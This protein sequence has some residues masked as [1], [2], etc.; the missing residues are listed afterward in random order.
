[1]ED[2][3]RVILEDGAV[4]DDHLA[5]EIVVVAEAVR[6]ETDVRRVDR[7]EGVRPVVR[8]DREVGRVAA[9]VAIGDDGDRAAEDEVLARGG[10][11][12]P[13]VVVAEP[14]RAEVQVPVAR[15]EEV[16]A[17]VALAAD[18]TA[19]EGDGAREAGV[20]ALELE[21][22]VA[23]LDD[24]RGSADLTA[25]GHETGA[26]LTV[27]SA[28]FD[29]EGDRRGP[30]QRRGAG[31][32]EI[33]VVGVVA[34]GGIAEDQRSPLGRRGAVDRQRGDGVGPGDVEGT[35][36][37]RLA[38]DAGV[39]HV[40]QHADPVGG[41]VRIDVGRAE[42]QFGHLAAIV[43]IEPVAAERDRGRPRRP[44]AVEEETP[45]VEL[46]RPGDGVGRVGEH[47]RAVA[48]GGEARGGDLPSHAR[49]QAVAAEVDHAF[50]RG[51]AVAEVKGGGVEI[52][53]SRGVGVD[54]DEAAAADIDLSAGEGRLVVAGISLHPEGVDIDRARQRRVGDAA[55]EVRHRRRSQA[56]EE[57]R[58]GGGIAAREGTREGGVLDAVDV[59]IGEE[60][61]ARRIEHPDGQESLGIAQRGATLDE[62]FLS[63]QVDTAELV[64]VLADGEGG[65]AFA[66]QPGG[67]KDDLSGGGVALQIDRSAL[68][69]RDDPDFFAGD[70]SRGV[71]EVDGGAAQEHR[72]RVAPLVLRDRGREV[73]G[74][75]A[76]GEGRVGDILRVIET[77]G[78]PRVE[79]HRVDLRARVVGEA[80]TG[81]RVQ[82]AEDMEGGRREVT[83]ELQEVLGTASLAVAEDDRLAR[84]GLVAVKAH[85]SRPAAEGKAEVE[86]RDAHL[87]GGGAGQYPGRS[88][89][90]HAGVV[91]E[92]AVDIADA[93]AEGRGGVEGIG[94]RGHA[95]ST[96]AEEGL[97]DRRREETVVHRQHQGAV[98]TG[99]EP[100][101]RRGGV[102][103]DLDDGLRGRK[104]TVELDRRTAG[105]EDVGR[106][107]QADRR[108]AVDHDVARAGVGHG[109]RDEGGA[110]VADVIGAAGTKQ[111]RAVGGDQAAVP[112]A[113]VGADREVGA[114]ALLQRIR[115]D[116]GSGQDELV[117]RLDASEVGQ[118]GQAVETRYEGVVVISKEA[119]Q[120]E[121][122]GTEGQ[123]LISAAALVA[124]GVQDGVAAAGDDVVT[125]GD[126][127]E[128]GGAVP[129]DAHGKGA[130]AQVD[131]GRCRQ[132]RRE[133]ER[134]APRLVA[135]DDG[136]GT[137]VDEG[138][139]E[140]IRPRRI[141]V[142]EGQRAAADLD[143]RGP[144][145]THDLA[146]V[147]PVGA[148]TT[149]GQRR[150]LHEQGAA[151]VQD[152]ALDERAAKIAEL[153]GEAVELD[154][155]ARLDDD[156]SPDDGVEVADRGE[157][158]GDTEGERPFVDLH[159]TLERGSGGQGQRP[160]AELRQHGRE[161]V[162]RVVAGVGQRDADRGDRGRVDIEA[163]RVG[164]E[165]QRRADGAGQAGSVIEED[166]AQA[167]RAG[168]RRADAEHITSEIHVLV[169]GE[170]IDG[171][172]SGK[173]R[174]RAARIV[175]LRGSGRE[176]EVAGGAVGGRHDAAR[177]IAGEGGGRRSAG[178][179]DHGPRPDDTVDQGRRGRE[180][181]LLGAGGS[182]V[183]IRSFEGEGGVGGTGQRTEG[184]SGGLAAAVDGD[185]RRAR[186]DRQGAGADGG[187]RGAGEVD[188]PQRAVGDGES[189]VD[190]ERTAGRGRAAFEHAGGDGHGAGE[191][192]ARGRREDH[193][194]GPD[195]R[196]AAGAAD[197]AGES[198]VADG[199]SRDVDPTGQRERAGEEFRAGVETTEG[200]GAA[201][202]GVLE[203]ATD[204][205]HAGGEDLG[206]DVAPELDRGAASSE[207]GVVPGDDVAVA[208]GR[209]SGVG[210]VPV[211]P[212]DALL[213]LA[214]GEGAGDDA[215]DGEHA[216][217][218]SQLDAPIEHDVAQL[219]TVA[220]EA[221]EIKGA[222]AAPARLVGAAVPDG[223]RGQD[224]H[225][226]LVAGRAGAGDEDAIGSVVA[227]GRADAGV[228]QH[229]GR[230]AVETE[231]EPAR[232]G[233]GGVEIDRAGRQA[234]G[235][236]VAEDET[237]LLDEGVAVVEVVGVE[238]QGAALALT[239]V[240]RTRAAGVDDAV[241]RH[242]PVDGGVRVVVADIEV[243]ITGPAEVGGD[244]AVQDEVKGRAAVGPETDHAVAAAVAVGD[245]QTTQEHGIEGAALQAGG[246]D[247]PGVTRDIQDAG[248]IL[249]VRPAEH[250]GGDI[251]AEFAATDEDLAALAQAQRSV[252]ARLQDAAGADRHGAREALGP[253]DVDDAVGVVPVRLVR[254][255]DD[256]GEGPSQHV[257]ACDGEGTAGV[258]VTSKAESGG[259]PAGRRQ[260]RSGEDGVAGIGPEPG[261]DVRR[262]GAD[263]AGEVG[264][265][266]VQPAE[267]DRHTA[268]LAGLVVGD[269]EIKPAAQEVAARGGQRTERDA[270]ARAIARAKRQDGRGVVVLILQ[271]DQL[272]RADVSRGL[273]AQPGAGVD[274]D[275]VS[276]DIRAR[277]AC[278]GEPEFAFLDRRAAGIGLR[279]REPKDAAAAPDE[280]TVRDVTG[281]EADGC[282]ARGGGVTVEADIP[283]FA[284]EIEAV[285]QGDGVGGVAAVQREDA[286]VEE[287]RTPDDRLAG[288][289][290]VHVDGR[291]V[292]AEARADPAEE[293]H[294][295]R[296]GAE[297][298][299]EVHVGL[300]GRLLGLRATEDEVR[301]GER[302][303]RR[304][305]AD[306]V[307]EVALGEIGRSGVGRSR[308]ERGDARRRLDE[309]DRVRAV[310][311]DDGGDR[312]AVP[313]EVVE[314]IIPFGAGGQEGNADDVGAAAGEQ[315]AGG[316]DEGGVSRAGKR[317][318]GRA[319]QVERPDGR[320]AE[321]E[322]LVAGGDLRVGGRGP[323]AGRGVDRVI[324]RD[325]RG[326]AEAARTRRDVFKE[327][328]VGISPAAHETDVRG[329][330]AVED[331]ITGRDADA[332]RRGA[333]SCELQGRGRIRPSDRSEAQRT[334]HR[335]VQ[336][337]AEIDHRL[338]ARQRERPEQF[339]PI[340][341]VL[342]ARGVVE[343]IILEADAT[344]A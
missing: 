292:G 195:L 129:V 86:L 315:A 218:G 20:V 262:D 130:A 153:L 8:A 120:A 23:G 220:V 6:I 5:F 103:A 142:V 93:G 320:G 209:T 189:R 312:F 331:L 78:G 66:D 224:D 286:R 36:V 34:V 4:A 22:A 311:R 205:P 324:S 112:G 114:A 221:V 216:S 306:D 13:H 69:G 228:G 157:G 151:H 84:V 233:G 25:Q 271:D 139:V 163:E 193:D 249:G 234:G 287:R 97:V 3:R 214:E 149:D 67:G 296:A 147:G 265:E 83:R 247:G 337:V 198:H 310:V 211:E 321:G 232:A 101:G 124:D 300:I 33:V 227:A 109:G 162:V 241:D 257:G 38:E 177:S 110:F 63:L 303:S 167:Q 64:G 73:R 202:R 217:A 46:D 26:A 92:E 49:E 60:P 98:G 333:I 88:D 225:A 166:A 35:A 266:I 330:R 94:H 179:L 39:R 191:G 85:R 329:E 54:R 15:A 123:E 117:V 118:G 51:R 99:A 341:R 12:G 100:V 246:T 297:R 79:V 334:D 323:R 173:K 132:G 207:G 223:D 180:D 279:V 276:G 155:R 201:G 168:R 305:G 89:G 339:V 254:S 106:G 14:Q 342:S 76:A 137:L 75:E 200:L 298:T 121:G 186:I 188:E 140:G 105:G 335:A 11:I 263:L 108:S 62:Q 260:R 282:A 144:S 318:A 210:V 171:P 199:L 229:E 170:R 160:R 165:M 115:P 107:V 288:A 181:Y 212:E 336:R 122:Q 80:A 127:L 175:D 178:P 150:A 182:Q 56:G 316:D 314:V 285:D 126:A 37:D 156:R 190:A 322:G 309:R 148:L 96:I 17:V 261:F 138:A 133:A 192:V 10:E 7:A 243:E 308:E 231:L 125:Q 302:R 340:D 289:A 81:A 255:A 143:E 91:A 24:G 213:A 68:A 242:H 208:D 290:E 325:Q 176:V 146:G 239:Q 240:L 28:A 128:I 71:D 197:R 90:E 317:A 65:L 203:R 280:A 259:R 235:A 74:V 1:M 319:L 194:A 57:S 278:A 141:P 250:P 326:V 42:H 29:A 158:V 21:E 44:G 226:V 237:S 32:H 185:D 204:R 273:H 50:D 136:K 245:D 134:P 111:Q 145:A 183:G 172:T 184:E 256:E 301:G 251:E 174:R 87:Q 154:G 19:L 116:D 291:A 269:E 47:E 294:L 102:G 113:V 27:G 58:P 272:V 293:T 72:R 43:V 18:L 313:G 41:P 169:G 307:A 135:A 270:G 164:A 274:L 343:G 277:G 258:A 152:R 30:S 48:A 52:D 82:A 95:P 16:V 328:G 244:G 264:L 332:G 45:A 119:L 161:G 248:L 61:V 299:G 53:A 304:A 253:R 187:S 230:R 40:G 159:V 222:V 131:V 104:R 236:G 2:V 31:D 59:G 219:E 338:S 77:Q 215:V 295:P 268:G 9:P 267:G 70:A 327:L 196:Q 238:D 252:D 344:A 283:G 275:V 206:E 55:D 281:D 284:A